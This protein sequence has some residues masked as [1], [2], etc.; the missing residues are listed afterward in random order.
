MQKPI[1]LIYT[2]PPS[3]E[4]NAFLLNSKLVAIIRSTFSNGFLCTNNSIKLLYLTQYV[5]LYYQILKKR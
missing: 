2:P 5:L 4:K 3:K 1:H